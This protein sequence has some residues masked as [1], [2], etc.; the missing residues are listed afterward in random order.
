MQFEIPQIILGTSSLGNLYQ[1]IS[2][3]NKTAVINEFLQHSKGIPVFDSAGKYGAGLALEAL[4]EGLKSLGVRPEQVVISNKLGWYRTEL[5]TPEPVFEKDVWKD[6]KNDAVQ[7][8]GYHGILECYHQGNE[9]LGE[10][11]A[12]FVSVHDPDEYLAA[13][14]DNTD[15]D[16]RYREI[17]SAY[18]AL[19]DLKKNGSVKAVGVGAKDW[20]VIQR[21]ATD[22]QLDWVM[23]AN[24][25]TVHSHPRELSAFI[26][27]LA[28]KNVHVINSAVFNGGF[29][30]GSEFY[31]YQLVD[32]ETSSGKELLQWR[33]QFYRL[34]REHGIEP[35]KAALNFGLHAPGVRSIAVSSSS[36]K[37]LRETITM[38]TETVPNA[39]WQSLLQHGLIANDSILLSSLLQ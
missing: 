18:T 7:K 8:M 9:L 39:F 3:Q 33:E 28:Q 11:K 13:A 6:I 32:Q 37:R 24:S 20:R 35:A 36:P 5:K 27:E 23:I 14:S 17:L 22:I 34:C 12:Q 38:A 2:Q 29:L 30:V 4:N 21:L 10:Y 26:K 25:M 31:N 15:R 19:F 1:A 16:A